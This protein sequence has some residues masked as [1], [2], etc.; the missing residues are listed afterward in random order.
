MV[1]AKFRFKQTFINTKKVTENWFFNKIMV[2]AN[3]LF[4]MDLHLFQKSKNYNCH[5]YN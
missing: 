5:M 2:Q 1:Q 3:I 4:Q